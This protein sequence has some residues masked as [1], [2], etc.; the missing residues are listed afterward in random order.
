MIAWARV[1]FPQ[2][3]MVK[4]GCRWVEDLIDYVKPTSNINVDIKVSPSQM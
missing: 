1:I 3:V 2:Y 4:R